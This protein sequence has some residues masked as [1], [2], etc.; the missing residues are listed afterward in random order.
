MKKIFSA[1]ILSLVMTTTTYAEHEK[2]NYNSQK[3]VSC[4]TP[5]NVKYILGETLGELPYMQGD[6]ISAA[7]DGKTFIQTNLIISVNLETKTFS[8]VEIINDGL[9]C[10]IGGGKNFR[11]NKPPAK[12]INTSLEN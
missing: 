6:G 3:P 7:T 12:K 11:F 1:F 2:F 10:I 8:V 4:T 9:A 5:D